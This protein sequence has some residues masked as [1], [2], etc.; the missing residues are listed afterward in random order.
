M[1]IPSAWARFRRGEAAH[2]RA[3]LLVAETEAVQ[4]LGGA[5]A[6]AVGA[7]GIDG[8][9]CA[10]YQCNEKVVSSHPC[11][12]AHQTI[13]ILLGL[14]ELGQLQRAELLVAVDHVV[15]GGAVDGPAPGSPARRLQSASQRAG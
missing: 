11:S 14:G 2:R 7:A 1:R 5:G 10:P 15:E 4:Q 6:N 12:F 9:P 13:V 3:Q 8:Q